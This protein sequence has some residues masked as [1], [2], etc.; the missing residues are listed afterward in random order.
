MELRYNC[1][2]LQ[3][4]QPFGCLREQEA[5][6]MT[7]EVSAETPVSRLDAVFEA[8]YGSGLRVRFKKGRIKDGF[9]TYTAQFTLPRCDLYFYHFLVYSEKSVRHWY[10]SGETGTS[11]GCGDRWQV[12]CYPDDLRAPEGF[13]GAVMY[14][15]FPDRF[16][17]GKACDLTGKLEPYHIHERWGETPLFQPD[18]HG[19]VLN[20]SF[21]GGNLDG[22]RQKLG[23]L[24]SLNVQVIYLNPISMAFSNHRYDTADYKRVDP[25][26]GTTED[27][28]ALCREA[29][30]LG[31]KVILDGVY[32][33]T[34]S[35][36]LYFDRKGV[37]G[38]GAYSDPDSPY[39]SWYDFQEYPDRYTC[40][41]GFP[42][43]PCVN[44]MDDSYL[45]FMIRGENSVVAHWLG[46]G[47]D[48]FRLDVADELPD[49]FI[50]MFRARVK[51][52]KP[53]AIVLGEVW[54][55]AS[56]KISYD[57]RRR[58]FSG[59]ELDS[60]MNYPFREAILAFMSGGDAAAFRQTVMTIVEHYP[61]PVLHCLMNSLSTHDTTRI[62]T[63]LGDSFDGTK[64]E[65]ADRRLSPELRPR[66]VAREM[67]A[68]LLQ[69][70]LPGMASI[71]YG[72][73]VG[74]E[75]FEDPLN[76]RCYPWGDEDEELLEFYRQLTACK[77]ALPA[78]RTGSIEFLPAPDGVID[79]VRCL[80]GQ[81]VRTIVNGSPETVDPPLNGK[82]LFLHYGRQ[83]KDC[84]MLDQWGSAM[85][86]EDT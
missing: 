18:E 19:E 6:Q 74:L 36:S 61:A 4:K 44:E 16:F 70:S 84:L 69:F 3:Y 45:D 30:G 25:M 43:L 11:E 66:A 2:S 76:R 20:N 26:L 14:Q 23:Y 37:F 29:H 58:Y 64:E 51:E 80:D 34:G 48:G 46:L 52:L 13:P 31:M 32:S 39:Q 77:A 82:L 73:E 28:A 7:V 71:F 35:N 8:E 78:L 9:I 62:L 49:E 40:W 42:T 59:G 38:G 83:E 50:A 24:R 85:I 67:S 21:F 57:I 60:V 86:L 12:T 68:A 33:H 81:R 53:D 72:D 79:F 15:I 75:G 1:L 5:C 17:K 56:N 47:A 63:L 41:W 22:I 54:E 27:F 65:K 10:R 55:D